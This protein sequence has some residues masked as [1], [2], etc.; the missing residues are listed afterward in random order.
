MLAA[1]VDTLR[2]LGFRVLEEKPDVVDAVRSRWHLKLMVTRITVVVRLRQVRELTEQRVEQDR[3]DVRELRRQ[4]DPALL[5]LGFQHAA[6]ILLVYVCDEA[7][8][9]AVA[10]AGQRGGGLATFE[11]VA[12]VLPD[13][14]HAYTGLDAGLIYLPLI[15]GLVRTVADP[16]GGGLSDGPAVEGGPKRRGSV[17]PIVGLFVGWMTLMLLVIASFAVLVFGSFFLLVLLG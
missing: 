12:V 13:A 8:S 5:P 10:L 14:V 11:R 6:V 4:R 17:W 15:N 7:S 2:R 16:D 1:R 3:A 9:E